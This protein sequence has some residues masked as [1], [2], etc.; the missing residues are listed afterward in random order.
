MSK[1]IYHQ[2]VASKAGNGAYKYNP[3]LCTHMQL[4]VRLSPG[5][6]R[7]SRMVGLDL[8]L[9]MFPELVRS[10]VFFF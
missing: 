9:V 2:M 4:F 6:V 7:L 8:L 10:L 1:Y 5:S 3:N